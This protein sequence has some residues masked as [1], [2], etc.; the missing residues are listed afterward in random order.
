M[1]K[2]TR[3]ILLNKRAH[4]FACECVRV[5]NGLAVSGFRVELPAFVFIYPAIIE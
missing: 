4:Q 1:F 5:V 3:L 2:K